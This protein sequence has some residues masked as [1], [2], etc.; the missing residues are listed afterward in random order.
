MLLFAMLFAMSA[1]GPVLALFISF[2]L[3]SRYLTGMHP[4][5]HHGESGRGAEPDVGVEI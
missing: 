2:R 4:P 5:P 3:A 1:F